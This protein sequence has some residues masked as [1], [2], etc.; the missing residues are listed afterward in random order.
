MF[1]FGGGGGGGGS[2]SGGGGGCGGGSGD[3]GSGGGSGGGCGG[4]SVGGDGCGVGGVG[5][6]SGG[7]MFFFCFG[8]LLPIFSAFIFIQGIISRDETEKLLNGREKG[9][10]LVRVSERVWGYTVSYKDDSKCKHFLVDTSGDTYQFFGTQ[11]LPHSSLNGLIEFHSER[12][13][14][15]IGQEILKIPCGQAR[16]PPDY[17]DLLIENTSM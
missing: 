8:L 4:G 12:P 13:I 6:R 15:G 3:G 9:S 5:G 17:Q 7:K 16:D 11:Q 2:G 10:F 1:D 14:S